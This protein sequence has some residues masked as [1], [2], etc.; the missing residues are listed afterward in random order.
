MFVK[1]EEE[2]PEKTKNLNYPKGMPN[3]MYFQTR[4]ISKMQQ[5]HQ[6]QQQKNPDQ[7]FDVCNEE[8][9]S[10]SIKKKE[11]NTENLLKKA[12]DGTAKKKSKKG[13][14]AKKETN[15][16]MMPQN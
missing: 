7:L 9:N 16:K 2:A 6:Q 12:S 11:K 8:L 3:W 1:V 13:T 10:L 14:K 4:K 5:T 15:A